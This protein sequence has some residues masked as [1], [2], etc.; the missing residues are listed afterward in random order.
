MMDKVMMFG[1]GIILLGGLGWLFNHQIQAR[2]AAE[3]TA[4]LAVAA[5]EIAERERDKIRES[6]E[7]EKVR[8]A[9]LTVE[10]EVARVDEQEA[11][12][13]LQDTGKIASALAGRPTWLQLKARKAT[14]KVWETIEEEANARPDPPPD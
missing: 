12:A 10:L 7:N 5:A 4:G 13:I 8:S 14:T 11:T 3:T 2:V 1:F 9:V 6:L